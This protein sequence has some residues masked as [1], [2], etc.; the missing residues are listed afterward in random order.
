MDT[1]TQKELKEVLDY[2][3]DTGK[4]TWLKATNNRIKVGGIAGCINKVHGYRAIKINGKIYKAHRLAF[5]Y[6]TGK[7]PPD[8]TDHINHSRD[9][10]RFVNLRKVTRLENLRNQSMYSKN[11]SGFTGV[12]WDKARNK[13][14]ANIKINGK[15]KHLGR[16]TDMD[17]AVIARKKAN[18]EHEFHENHGTIN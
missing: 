8:D 7:F 16:F 18:I 10:N 13:W 15:S 11:K 5:L 17:D 4:F 9:D 1:L 3:A 14:K 2:D 6:M 12:Y